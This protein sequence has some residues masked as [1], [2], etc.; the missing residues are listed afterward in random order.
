MW[1]ARNDP[2]VRMG[3]GAS[4]GAAIYWFA[5]AAALEKKKE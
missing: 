2:S 1:F 3:I 5:S 4:I